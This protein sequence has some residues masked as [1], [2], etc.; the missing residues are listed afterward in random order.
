M[1]PKGFELISSLQ[2]LDLHEN[3]FDG[4]LDGMFFLETNASHVDLS[5]NMLVSS[6][7]QR[8]LPGMSESI[9]LLNLSHNQ[10]SGSLLN[11]GDMQLF[12][13]VKVLDL[14]YNQLSGELPGFDFAYELQVLR[15]S[16]N[17][18]SGYIPNDLLKGD[19][20]LLNE[21]D[22]SANNLSGTSLIT[23]LAFYE[24]LVL[25]YNTFSGL[26]LFIVFMIASHVVASSF[27]A[28]KHDYVNNTSCP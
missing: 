16:N 9:K 13:S 19:S 3:M 17:K 24:L 28:N 1:I 4:H 10:L 26:V 6:S 20:L 27:R 18:F 21:L 11:G 22:L 5:G 15:L 8:L 25:S 14:S 2:V 23:A 12:A 7:S